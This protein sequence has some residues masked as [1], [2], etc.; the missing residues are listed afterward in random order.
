M[1]TFVLA[2][3][4]CSH[5]DKSDTSSSGPDLTATALADGLGKTHDAAPSSDASMV[6]ATVDASTGTALISIDSGG[7]TATLD[8][9]TAAVG[10]VVG[11]GD[12]TVY[13]ADTDGIHSVTASDGT[14]TLIDGTGSYLPVALEIDGTNLVFTGTDPVTSTFGVFRIPQVGG[15][16]STLLSGVSEELSGVVVAA[17]GSLYATGGGN[18]Y[19]VADSAD[20]PLVQGVALGTPAGIAVSPDES[21]LLVSAIGTDGKSELLLI[22]RDSGDKSDFNDT[23]GANVGSGGLH[24][25]SASTSTFAWAGITTGGTGT[26]YRVT[27]N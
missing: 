21:T 16:V 15:D 26:V 11:P 23:I 10:V 5:G 7:A 12:G 27:F 19:A 8:A 13:V 17:D 18:V 25:A 2:L 4:A 1:L 22:D 24:R 20:T 3:A 14:N 6:Y 9:F